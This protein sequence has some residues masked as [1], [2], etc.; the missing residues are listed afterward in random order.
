MI[1]SLVDGLNSG[2]RYIIPLLLV[3][4]PLYAISVTKV[5]VYEV[6]V[7]GAKEKG[8]TAGLVIG[9]VVA[10]EVLFAGPVSGASM[11]PARS[12]GPA[13]VSGNLQSLWI[14]LVAPTLGA[15]LSVPLCGFLR[16]SPEESS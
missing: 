10:F 16:A 13:L 3:G 1:E 11:N 12:L 5:Q 9:A 2:A 7:E 14:Y 15:L 6:F 8:I 4:I